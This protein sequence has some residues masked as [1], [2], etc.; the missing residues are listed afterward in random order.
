MVRWDKHGGL[1]GGDPSV[2]DS[3]TPSRL[4]SAKS[5]MSLTTNLISVLSSQHIIPDVLPESLRD[6]FKPTTI[7]TVVY[8]T[9]AQTD[10][11]NIVTRSNVLEE[12]EISISP[13]QPLPLDAI[14]EKDVKYTLVMTDPDAPSRAEPKYRQWRHWVV[15]PTYQDSQS[16]SPGDSETPNGTTPYWPPGPPPGSGLHRY[17]FLLFGE[18]EGGVNVPQGAVEYGTKLEERRSWNSMKFAEEYKLTLV[19]VNFFLCQE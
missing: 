15:R 9:G 6:A 19:G 2:L 1:L 5:N 14:P 3:N 10:L 8:P 12:P 4:D 7:F 17:T 18:P 13:Q 16:Q 11:G